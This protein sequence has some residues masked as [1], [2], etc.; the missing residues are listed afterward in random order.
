MFASSMDTTT[1]VSTELSI[2]KFAQ[3]I[4]FSVVNAGAELEGHI[5]VD[6]WFGAGLFATSLPGLVAK[7]A[8]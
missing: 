8:N 3:L 5:Q 1:T 2:I 6:F 4:E 7:N